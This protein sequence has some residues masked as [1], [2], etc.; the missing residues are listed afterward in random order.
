MV[1]PSLPIVNSNHTTRGL[2]R[3]ISEKEPAGA[4]V[5]AAVTMCNRAELAVAVLCIEDPCISRIQA[6]RKTGRSEAIVLAHTAIMLMRTIGVG[7]IALT[8]GM[9]GAK[10]L[11]A[12]WSVAHEFAHHAKE[13]G[14]MDE[15]QFDGYLDNHA[16]DFLK[17][18]ETDTPTVKELEEYLRRAVA[19]EFPTVFTAAQAEKD[20]KQSAIRKGR[21]WK[22]TMPAVLSQRLWELVDRQAKKLAEKAGI[23]IAAAR[24]SVI[25]DRLEGGRSDA[26]Q[27]ATTIH[28]HVFRLEQGPGFI[29]GVGVLSRQEADQMEYHAADVQPVHM[30]AAPGGYTPTSAQKTY[31]AGRDGCC[32]FPGCDVPAM[33]C[34]KDHIVPYNHKEPARGGPTDVRNLQSLC[35]T[36]HNLKTNG[37]WHASTNDGAYS[38]RWVNRHGEKFITY[39]Q[40]TG[41]SEIEGAQP[42]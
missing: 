10:H 33:M 34:D 4:A 16:T 12:M 26:T 29:P 22:L 13:Q 6:H 21:D 9:I 35:R 40:G 7:T 20:A 28:V 32:R 2:K 25:A 1:S 11:N 27:P 38:I 31:V 15:K 41:F 14:V 8:T 3:V 19:T 23:D 24:M 37:I 36:H 39:P 42:Q 5:R 30:P 17:N 18:R